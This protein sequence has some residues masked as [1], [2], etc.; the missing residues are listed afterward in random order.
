MGSFLYKNFFTGLLP[1]EWGALGSLRALNL[2]DRRGA[3]GPHGTPE[4]NAF[5]APLPCTW[6]TGMAAM[7]T[8][9]RNPGFHFAWCAQLHPPL[10]ASRRTHL[11]YCLQ[12][13]ETGFKTSRQMC[14]IMQFG[15]PDFTQ[16]FCKTVL[17]GEWTYFYGVVYYCRYLT[18]TANYV[19]CR[20]SLLPVACGPAEGHHCLRSSCAAGAP[21]SL[22]RSPHMH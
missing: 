10:C 18:I 5:Q 9:F 8:P 12:R 7:R 17:I 21:H 19:S 6:L 1:A 20:S 13:E 4:T 3:A 11:E 2:N 14:G 15:N 22:A 16:R